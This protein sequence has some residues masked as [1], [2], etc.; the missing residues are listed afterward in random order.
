VAHG[1]HWTKV[2]GPFL[3]Y[4]NTGGSPI[5]MYRDAVTASSKESQ[6]W[7]YSWVSGVGYPRQKESV[8]K[9]LEMLA[10]I[11]S[12]DGRPNTASD[13]PRMPANWMAAILKVRP[14]LIVRRMKQFLAR[15]AWRSVGLKSS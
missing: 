8:S 13:L 6:H 7:P 9:K 2:I 11:Y 14:S 3:L 4:M 10:T 12:S 15:E 5:E 1:E